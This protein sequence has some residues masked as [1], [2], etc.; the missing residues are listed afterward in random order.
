MAPGD[1]FDCSRCSCASYAPLADAGATISKSVLPVGDDTRELYLACCDGM[2]HSPPRRS[3]AV[4]ALLSVL[5]E[6]DLESP[7]A[8]RN[9]LYAWRTGQLA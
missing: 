2:E 1:V 6:A 7:Y 8:V 4:D 5:S 3:D 9:L